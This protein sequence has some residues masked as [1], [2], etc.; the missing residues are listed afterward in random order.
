[1]ESEL[2]LKNMRW[3]GY[4][5]ELSMHLHN[6]M[7]KYYFLLCKF[8]SLLKYYHLLWYLKLCEYGGTKVFLLIQIQ[9][10]E[11]SI[12][13]ECICYSPFIELAI[14]S[15]LARFHSKKYV[16]CQIKEV[17]WN[18]ILII[19]NLLQILNFYF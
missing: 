17:Y 18:N 13:A 3:W 10:K 4:I 12:S 16:E 19:K 7:V 5:L 11:Y 8:D 1:M 6:N 9:V 15:Y 14:Q 2:I